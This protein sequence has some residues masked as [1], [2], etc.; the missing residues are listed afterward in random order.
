MLTFQEN[1]SLY[2]ILTHPEIINSFV[3]NSLIYLS[4]YSKFFFS[5]NHGILQ[6]MS[7]MNG[8]L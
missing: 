4:N 7:P 2:Y 8:H 3:I 5:R 6:E 1:L